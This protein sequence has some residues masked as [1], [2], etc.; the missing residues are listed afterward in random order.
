MTNKKVV[1]LIKFQSV[2]LKDHFCGSLKHQF[3]LFLTTEDRRDFLKKKVVYKKAVCPHCKE[4]FEFKII[5][6]R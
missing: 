3:K 2:L 6:M 1:R 4:E 5:N